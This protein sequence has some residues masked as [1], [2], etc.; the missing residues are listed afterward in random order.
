MG[1]CIVNQNILQENK[2]IIKD[3]INNCLC[4]IKY[5]DKNIN[6]MGFLCKIPFLDNL[7]PVLITNSQILKKDDIT[8]GKK[9]EFSLFNEKDN[10]NH[11]IEIEKTTKKFTNDIIAI[12]EIKNKDLTNNNFLQIDGTLDKQNLNKIY[13]KRAILL[14]NIKGKNVNYYQGEIGK[15][16]E[17]DYS[18]T[19]F[20]QSKATSLGS[21]IMN[22]LNNKV[23]GIN[24]EVKDN[25]NKGIFIIKPIEDFNKNNY[26]NKNI[27]NNENNLD[28]KIKQNGEASSPSSKI[29]F[30]NDIKTINNNNL[31][32]NK[33]ENKDI[34]AY[35]DKYKYSDHIQQIQNNEIEINRINKEEKEISLIFDILGKEL[36]LD[37]KAYSIFNEVIEQ[38]INKYLWL[39]VENNF[40]FE[41]DGKTISK[42]KTVKENGLKDNSFIKIIIK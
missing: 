22:S 18:F 17:E 9:I 2:R 1:S 34:I 19:Y 10:I 21:P 39:K 24:I 26:K 32:I 33:E 14:Y 4:K 31:K 6:G 30:V 11:K 35:K 20:N 29:I 3:Q 42:D 37:V 36:Y 23:L 28:I 15:I 40:D 41:I 12:I 27:S 8:I 38:L 13:N 7:L 16:N 5:N 25:L